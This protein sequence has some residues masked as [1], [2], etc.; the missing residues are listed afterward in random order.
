MT[1]MFLNAHPKKTSADVH[2]SIMQ[3]QCIVFRSIFECCWMQFKGKDSF[4][5][6]GVIVLLC[7]HGCNWCKT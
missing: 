2:V 3:M 1:R 7:V 6:I 4:Q 5:V